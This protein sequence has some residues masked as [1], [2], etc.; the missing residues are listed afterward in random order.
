VHL[1]HYSGALPQRNVRIATVPRL[2]IERYFAQALI[3]EDQSAVSNSEFRETDRLRSEVKTDQT[4]R[5]GHGDK[6]LNRR[7]EFINREMSCAADSLLISSPKS[8]S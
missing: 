6:G 7:N 8:H 2:W 4:R 3:Q 1:A 5:S